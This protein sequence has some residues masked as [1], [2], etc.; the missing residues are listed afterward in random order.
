MKL[1][2]WA[3]TAWRY[4]L[5][6]SGPLATSGAHFLA[7]LL[8]VRDLAADSFGLFSFVLVL[9]P[10]AMSATG[11]LLIIPVTTSLAEAAETRAR[12]TKCC[13]KLNLVL[14]L[15]TALCVFAALLAAHATPAPAILLG[16]FGG[17]LTFRWFGR[18]FAY[19]EGRMMRAVVS[20]ITYALVLIAG[21]AVLAFSHSVTLLNGAL[22]MLAAGLAGL[23][24]L[25][26]RF[27]A[28][29]LRALFAGRLG[30]YRAT[31]RDLTSWSLL[32]VV[33][34]EITV[35]A[36]AYLVT[37]ISGAGTFALLA[38]GM[39]LLR[40]ASLVQSALPD[41]ERPLMVRQMVSRDWDGLNRTSRDFGITLIAML[42]VT[43]AL[44]AV[45]LIW[46]PDLVLKRGY[47]LHDVMLV[48]TLSAVIMAVRALRAPP[49]VHLQAAGWFK[50]MAAIGATSS[51]ISILAVLA[52]LF[53]FGP[54][55][56]LGGVLLG[57]LVI[58]FR[59]RAL[60]RDWQAQNV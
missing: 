6:T 27:F 1:K 40:P 34:T 36:H 3:N 10:F 23:A 9:V 29:Q 49:A 14:S 11:A 58:L 44:D 37:F 22:V 47:G 31:F 28:D 50:Q 25:G 41:L 38:L 46:F 19:V 53:T 51:V 2:P 16:L 54:I 5:S 15:L 56:S 60:V 33:F 26:R 12:V 17:V 4:G 8:F 48:T 43:L 13:L 52:L 18:C 55:A 59:C 21:L 32:G 7:S 20:D 45:L 24:P 35:N 39:L 30:L 57:E 42:L